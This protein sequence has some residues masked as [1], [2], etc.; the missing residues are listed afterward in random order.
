MRGDVGREEVH[1]DGPGMQTLRILPW[2]CKQRP[3]KCVSPPLASEHAASGPTQ[4]W[5]PSSGGTA[6]SA[7]WFC[8]ADQPGE[9]GSCP[10]QW[11]AP[12]LGRATY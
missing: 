6:V 1:R 10:R 12:P 3:P 4:L 5:S 9:G 11:S 7:P 8:A 2:L